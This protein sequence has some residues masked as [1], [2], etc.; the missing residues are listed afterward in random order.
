MVDGLWGQGYQPSIG[1]L[2]SS[3][4]HKAGECYSSA[5]DRRAAEWDA[6]MV[7][8]WPDLSYAFPPPPLLS[9]C[10]VCEYL[11]RVGDDRVK[12]IVGRSCSQEVG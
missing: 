7:T 2:A 5:P 9:K 8:S 6:F 1:L 10:L 12:T 4:F 11:T 3:G